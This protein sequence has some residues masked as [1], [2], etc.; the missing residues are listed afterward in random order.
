MFASCAGPG[1]LSG[2]ATPLP[3]P[4]PTEICSASPPWAAETSPPAPNERRFAPLRFARGEDPARTPAC[5]DMRNP[6]RGFFAFRDLLAPAD[7]EEL[8]E[9]GV[10]LIY[11]QALLAA[12]R[13]RPLDEP[14][15]EKVRAGFAAARRA[16]LKVLPRFYYAAD[17]KAADAR[18]TRAL[19]H[20]ATL[21]PVLREN[22][23]VIAALH[24]GFV[25]AWGEWHP[26]ERADLPARKRIVEALLA[27]LPSDR[28]VLLRRPFYKQALFDPSTEGAA[29]AR[30]GHLNDCFLASA[31]DQG[32]YRA[33]AERSYAA[34][35]GARVPVG[36]ETCAVNP[37]R[38]ECPTALA[39]LE[40]H[41]WSFLNRD[42]HT[43]VLAGWREGGCWDTVACRLGYRLLLTRQWTPSVVRA[44]GTLAAWVSLVN[45][46]YARPINPRPVAVV[47]APRS[48]SSATKRIGI[49]TG[50]DAQSLTPGRPHDVCLGVAVPL[51]LAPGIYKV[52]LALPDPAPTLRNDSRYAVQLGGGVGW[53]A[54]NG[55]NWLDAEV[56][57]T[58]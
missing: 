27:A 45:D 5:Q 52:G 9:E 48:L 26:E 39:E 57:V 40:R 42:Y 38:S 24:A 29:L 14:L 19:E 8:R 54:A 53:D 35:D 7:L 50:F 13:N 41:H 49:A 30:L 31:D 28:A 4:P 37:P 46:G 22:A 34:R 56:E 44:G 18:P 47:L 10:T 15:L 12:Y 20:I 55:I 25:G 23:D 21:A 3:A 33:P 17:D 6:E 32:T 36:G 16:G 11:G 1:T 58:R 43:D 2:G 51:D